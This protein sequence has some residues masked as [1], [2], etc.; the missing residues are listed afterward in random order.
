MTMLPP[1][2]LG[3]NLCVPRSSG[4]ALTNTAQHCARGFFWNAIPPG[5][6]VRAD[7]AWWELG[8]MSVPWSPNKANG[9]SDEL[10]SCDYPRRRSHWLSSDHVT[11]TVI[12]MTATQMGSPHMRLF[13][14]FTPSQRLRVA[15]GTVIIHHRALCQLREAG[16]K[17]PA[18]RTCVC[19]TPQNC[20]GKT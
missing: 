12:L 5:I 11:F 15:E 4:S 16:R 8:R 18:K 13:L 19:G 7:F 9:S 6:A 14:C 20:L 1:D 3:T 10:G 17:F 2:S